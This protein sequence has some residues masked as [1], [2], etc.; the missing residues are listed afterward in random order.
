MA[1]ESANSRLKRWKFLANIVS[2]TQIMFNGDYVPVVG[3]LINAFRLPLLFDS[4]SD[5]ELSK[6]IVHKSKITL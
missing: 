6:K 1:V 3:S 4:A 2:N 5:L